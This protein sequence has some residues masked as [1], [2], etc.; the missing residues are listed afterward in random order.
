MVERRSARDDDGANDETAVTQRE[1]RG[2]ERCVRAQ[3]RGRRVRGRP[4][5]TGEHGLL[6]DVGGAIGH[7]PAADAAHRARRRSVWGRA[8]GEW[9]GWV[10]AVAGDLVHLCAE[11]PA[12]PEGPVRTGEVVGTGR[13]GAVLRLVDARDAGDHDGQARAVMPWEELSWEPM[14]EPPALGPGTRVTGRVVGLTVEHGPE[15]SPRALA[16]T[17]WPAIALALPP[18]SSVAAHVEAVARGRARLRTLTAPRAVAIVATDEL[19]PGAAPGATVDAVVAAVNPAA[20]ALVLE[21][22]ALSDR[23]ARAPR[24]V[25]GGPTPGRPAPGRAASDSR[26]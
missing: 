13:S 2:L 22:L 18:G 20:G 8:A 19:P 5:A 4:V 21:R 23:A 25:P 10:V 12:A 24:P 7:V 17:P 14:L 11:R 15:L 1:R 6:V 9:E 26:S 3:E 16:P